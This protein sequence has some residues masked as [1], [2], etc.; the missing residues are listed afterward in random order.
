[1]KDVCP[2]CGGRPG[3]GCPWSQAKVYVLWCSEYSEDGIAGIFATREK[4][5]DAAKQLA[6]RG[7]VDDLIEEMILDRMY[8]E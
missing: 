5:E 7:S 4:A 6:Y 2:A 1:M 8:A 3:T